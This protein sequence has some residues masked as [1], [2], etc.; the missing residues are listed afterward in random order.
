LGKLNNM[1]GEKY[2]RLKVVSFEGLNN[3]RKA[4]WLCEC[5][6]GTSKVVVGSSL[7]SGCTVS[8]GCYQSSEAKKRFSK[9]MS[10]EK[11]GRLTVLSREGT[12]ISRKS[13]TALWR[14]KCDCGEETVVRGA[15]LRNGT[16]TSCGCAQRE[17]ASIANTTHAL[18]KT[19]L[20]RTWLSMKKRCGNSND[21]NYVYYGGRGIKLCDEWRNDFVSFENWAT[22][23]GYSDE[24]T[25]DRIDV[26]G[27]YEPS[28]CRWVSMKVQ[29]NNTRRNNYYE[30]ED[31]EY[32]LSQISDMCGIRYSVLYKRL[33]RGWS[34][35]DAVSRPVRDNGYPG[36]GENCENGK[37]N[38]VN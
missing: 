13:K 6:C 18:S 1:V 20:Y 31:G 11:I 12:Y 33:N 9:D 35:E 17:N 25:I 37:R 27:N 10:G 19:R 22:L 38:R 14:C 30:F 3:H 26:D 28:N 2:G 4:T 34:L 24:L 7:K 8:C 16:T 23:N 21:K 15:S 36:K 32:T 5:E 29:S